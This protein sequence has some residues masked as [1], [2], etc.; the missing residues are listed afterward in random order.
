[1][2]PAGRVGPEPL[3]C[4]ER[5]EEFRFGEGVR[6]RLDELRAPG[7]R[8]EGVPERAIDLLER[9]V[10]WGVRG[11]GLGAGLGLNDR[12]PDPEQSRDQQ[13]RNEHAARL[14]GHSAVEDIERAVRCLSQRR[15]RYQSPPRRASSTTAA[16]P[17]MAI[18]GPSLSSEAVTW[19]ARS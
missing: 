18:G 9:L 14:P 2:S 6:S 1:M 4:L 11:E 19:T 3:L 16:T 13:K 17:M 10:R 8:A 5:P 7:R 15:R 12:D